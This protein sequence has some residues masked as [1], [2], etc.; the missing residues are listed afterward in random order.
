MLVGLRRRSGK[1]D[2]LSG[3]LSYVRDSLSPTSP[4]A[5][6]RSAPKALCRGPGGAGGAGARSQT[7]AGRGS[8]RALVG[9]RSASSHGASR[10]GRCSL[11]SPSSSLLAS[12]AAALGAYVA[13]FMATST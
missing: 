1:L 13:V 3:T 2:S 10:L 4:A 12:E 11:A 7:R 5:W 9:R 6:P 8:D